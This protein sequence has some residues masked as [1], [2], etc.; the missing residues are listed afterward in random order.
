MRV[1]IKE[2]G[3]EYLKAAAPK[4]R[5]PQDTLSHL[6]EFQESETEAFISL[7][8][9]N[10]NRLILAEV[11]TT[12]LLNVC[13]AHPR[14]IFRSAVRNN[15]AAI[16][17]AHNHPSGDPTPSA[18]DIRITRQLI[19]AGKILGIKILDHVIIGQPDKNGNE[20]YVSMREEGLLEFR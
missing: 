12:G 18:E 17:I 7:N 16:V 3:V 6:K 10:K 2:A 9:D 15:A 13:L 4:V 5:T 11:V 20:R 8:L 14:A 19:E 1:I